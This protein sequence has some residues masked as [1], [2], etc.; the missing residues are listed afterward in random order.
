[1]FCDWYRKALR[2]GERGAARLQGEAEGDL[3]YGVRCTGDILHTG[4]FTNPTKFIRLER[5]PHT[6]TKHAPAKSPYVQTTTV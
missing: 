3:S 4:L 5:K 1:M 6:L 2:L